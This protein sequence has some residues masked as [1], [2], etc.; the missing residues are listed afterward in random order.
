MHF[1]KN[2]RIESKPY[3]S[4]LDGT[5]KLTVGLNE[6]TLTEHIKYFKVLHIQHLEY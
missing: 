4:S 1:I 6:F 2:S 3:Y 5:A